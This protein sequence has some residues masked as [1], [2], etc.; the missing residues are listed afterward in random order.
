MIDK[1][2]SSSGIMNYKF[3]IYSISPIFYLSASY[4]LL[5]KSLNILNFKFDNLKFLIFFLGSGVTYY[6][7][8]RFSMTHSYEF[9]TTSLLIY[10]CAKYYEKSNLNN[11]YSMLIPIAIFVNR[12]TNYFLLIIPIIKERKETNCKSLFCF[13][14][15]CFS[16]N[17]SLPF[18]CNLWCN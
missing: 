11:R 3:L 7:F 12:W 9:F 18:L 5:I 15:C 1:F 16:L 8:E 4:I 10:S 13:Y 14:E 17:F 6:A 2:L